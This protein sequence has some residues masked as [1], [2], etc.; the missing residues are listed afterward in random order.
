MYESPSLM[1]LHHAMLGLWEPGKMWPDRHA[2]MH[3]MSL[4]FQCL[5]FSIGSEKNPP[6]RTDRKRGHS[7]IRETIHSVSIDIHYDRNACLSVSSISVYPTSTPALNWKL[8]IWCL[9]LLILPLH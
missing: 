4:L 9:I 8:S 2:A 6:S 1:E 3:G 5:L 7:I